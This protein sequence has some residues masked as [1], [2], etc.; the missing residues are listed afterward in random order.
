MHHRIRHSPRSWEKHSTVNASAKTNRKQDT[1]IAP[2]LLENPKQGLNRRRDM[3][4]GGSREER[5]SC[6]LKVFPNPTLA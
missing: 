3:I 5:K 1:E 6:Q 4:R 2:I